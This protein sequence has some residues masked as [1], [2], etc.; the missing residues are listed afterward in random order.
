M[1]K[2]TKQN[3][4]NALVVAN[5]AENIN[6]EALALQ[7]QIEQHT[8]ELQKCL[9]ELEKK[10]KLSEN[11]VQFMEVMDKLEHAQD[12]LLQ[13]ESFNTEVYKLRFCATS[14]YREEDVFTIGNREIIIDFV[15]YIREKII[16]KVREIESQLIA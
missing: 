5:E 11:R 6:R 4:R 7:K 10:K 13:E 12:I 9:A 15:R 2:K 8:A 1:E 14:N 16:A 3:E